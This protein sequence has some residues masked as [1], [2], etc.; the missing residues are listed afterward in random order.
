LLYL[1][2]QNRDHYLDRGLDCQVINAGFFGQKDPADQGRYSTVIRIDL[3]ATRFLAACLP[4]TPHSC[5]R[6]P[7]PIGSNDY[8]VMAR[9][10]DLV[11][12]D[13]RRFA[14]ADADGRALGRARGSAARNRRRSSG[15][16]FRTSGTISRP[17]FW[18][19]PRNP[20]KKSLN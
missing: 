19:A 9:H 12:G 8:R 7:L 10:A 5:R 15:S 3:D 17:S 16:R 4:V 13:R 6:T 1:E 11:C 20:S 14:E 2:R 18:K